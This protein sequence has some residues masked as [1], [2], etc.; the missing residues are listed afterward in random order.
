MTP[1]R[2]RVGILGP[3]VMALSLTPTSATPRAEPSDPTPYPRRIRPVFTTSSSAIVSFQ[4]GAT[5]TPPKERGQTA[6]SIFSPNATNV[7]I[8]LALIAVALS[9]S[10]TS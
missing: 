6:A 4:A 7:V 2:F 8:T 1:H 5:A 3:P 9:M 10:A